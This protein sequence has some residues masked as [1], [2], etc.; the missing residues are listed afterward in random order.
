MACQ[1]RAFPL[2]FRSDYSSDTID[3]IYQQYRTHIDLYNFLVTERGSIEEFEALKIKVVKL[4]NRVKVAIL[5]KRD[6]N[7]LNALSLEG[8]RLVPL[9]FDDSR[10]SCSDSPV[11]F[12]E[13]VIEDEWM[14]RV[15]ESTH[16]LYDCIKTKISERRALEAEQAAS[17]REYSFIE[18]LFFLPDILLSKL[19]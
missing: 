6:V 13:N 10:V 2:F 4:W 9:N 5:E 14:K 11:P 19:F 15:L 17:E 1:G 18:A 16:T 12:D 8:Y 3:D 7:T